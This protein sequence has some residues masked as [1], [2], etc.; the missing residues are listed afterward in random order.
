LAK[1]VTAVLS[2]ESR[3]GTTNLFCGGHSVAIVVS[4]AIRN[5]QLRKQIGVP[6]IE[7][8]VQDLEQ[9]IKA[10]TSFGPV[11]LKRSDSPKSSVSIRMKF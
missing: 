1:D 5:L 3:L 7:Q 4:V 2:G 6:V 8:V 10:N 11:A 9:K